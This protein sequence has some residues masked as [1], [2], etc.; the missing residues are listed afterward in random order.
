VLKRIFE[1]NSGK[2]MICGWEEMPNAGLHNLY[3]S[4]NNVHSIIEVVK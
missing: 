2:K 3:S 4:P 1:L